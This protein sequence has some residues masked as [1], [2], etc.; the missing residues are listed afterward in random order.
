[1]APEGTLQASEGGKQTG[2]LPNY[3]ACHD[4]TSNNDQHDMII[5][6]VQ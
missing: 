6:R 4:M 3:D 2:D 1:M 5:Q